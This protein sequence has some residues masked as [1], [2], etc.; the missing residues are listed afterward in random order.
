MLDLMD[1]LVIARDYVSPQWTA[2]REVRVRVGLERRRRT[3][4]RRRS[5]LAVTAL[6]LAAA[7]ALFFTLKGSFIEHPVA[8]VPLDAPKVAQPSNL[9]QLPDG[10]SVSARSSDARVQPVEVTARAVTLKLESGT[11]KFS[12]TPDPARPFR[13]IAH[14]VTVTVLG[15]VFDVS[16]EAN[17]EKS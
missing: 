3:D 6:S 12:V 8:P 14:N 15:T 5:V 1:C 13:V 9:F 11:A 7:I 16:I 2:E 10:S 17:G 4:A